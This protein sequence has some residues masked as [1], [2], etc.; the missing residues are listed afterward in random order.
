L[1]AVGIATAV[2]FLLLAVVGAIYL[3]SGWFSLYDYGWG[4]MG[5]AGAAGV[6]AAVLLMN[7]HGRTPWVGRRHR[8]GPPAGTW[9]DVVPSVVAGCVIAVALG[10]S[11]TRVSIALGLRPEHGEGVPSVLSMRRE[12]E[13]MWDSATVW[14]GDAYL[15]DATIY[16]G[17]DNRWFWLVDAHFKCPSDDHQSLILYVYPDG[18]IHYSIVE[19][20]TEVRQE[21]PIADSDWPLDSEAALE[22]FAQND[23][24]GFCLR[25]TGRH[26]HRLS[27]ERLAVSDD[28]PVVWTLRLDACLGAPNSR[29]YIDATTGE[30]LDPDLL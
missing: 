13:L 4:V 30:F 7:I 2:F 12:L 26:S 6:L 1:R 27:L 9:V 23:E 11:L 16:L 3:I 22:A 19:W 17:E 18:S 10:Y 24:I 20:T 21:D 8:S 5:V 28:N 15:D 25:S 14:R 29:Y